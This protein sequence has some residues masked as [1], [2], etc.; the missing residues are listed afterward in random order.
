MT[1][2]RQENGLK[3]KRKRNKNRH[4][5]QPKGRKG[6]ETGK[7][8]MTEQDGLKSRG[9]AGPS[10]RAPIGSKD[11]VVRGEGTK[12]VGGPHG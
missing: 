7:L 9:T 11:K 2:H 6:E 4:V 8:E 10:P 3:R 12:V 1:K 5:L